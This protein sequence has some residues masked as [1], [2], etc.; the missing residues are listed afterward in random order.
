MQLDQSQVSLGKRYFHELGCVQCHELEGTGAR[1]EYLSLADLGMD[2][3]CLS[4][5]S[6]AWPRYELDQSQRAAIRAAIGQRSERLT[7]QQQIVLT[8][9]TFRC[10]ACHGRDEFDG[11]SDQRNEYFR[12]TNENLGPQG[13]IPP[14]LTGVGGKLKSKWLREVLVSG[15][16][17]RPYMMTRMPQYGADNVAHLVNLFRQV[18]ELP[19]D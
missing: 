5:R 6:G 8:M 17:I 15:R 13:R 10:F 12:T 16:A 4:S 14:T 7:D 19:G 1:R 9:E 18:D 11:V 3:G 2:Q